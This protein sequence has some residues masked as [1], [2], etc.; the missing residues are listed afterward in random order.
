MT[1][2][3]SAVSWQKT[4]TY[5]SS[6]VDTNADGY[7]A[8]TQLLV[9]ADDA[10]PIILYDKDGV[11]Q[12][13]DFE[14]SIAAGDTVV[15]SSGHIMPDVRFSYDGDYIYIIQSVAAVVG[16]EYRI[17]KY[18]LDGTR[19][20]R[21]T[22]G[23]GRYGAASLC[24]DHNEKIYSIYGGGAAERNPVQ[25]SPVDGSITR[26]YASYTTYAVSKN[27]C[28]SVP[29]NRAFFG[30]DEHPSDTIANATVI[31]LALDSDNVI[32]YANANAVTRQICTDHEYVYTT[33]I[34]GIYDTTSILKL[35]GTTLA[36]EDSVN[37]VGACRLWI[38][39]DDNLWVMTDDSN[40]DKILVLDVDDLSTLSTTATGENVCLGTGVG[41]SRRC[42]LATLGDPSADTT[43]PKSQTRN[44][45]FPSGYG[46]LEGE[47]C[48]VLADGAVHPNVTVS[49]GL[50]TL[51]DTYT[52][53]HIGLRYDSRV[54]PMKID[55]EVHKKHITHVYPQ[56]Y[57]S[58][59]GKYGETETTLFTI[60]FRDAGDELNDSPDLY[61]GHKEL[62]FDGS[63]NR[64]GD[65]WFK[66]EQPLPMNLIGTGVRMAVENSTG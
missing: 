30:L 14:F 7:V 66:Q 41:K 46:H 47:E 10:S 11:D 39:Y 25:L 26:T 53:T 60:V 27:S 56:L 1:N 12:G 43:L 19:L 50:A 52:T 38:G 8:A 45:W 16:E 32:G 44:L 24:V 63:W 21:Q 17:H 61:T 5:D 55:G 22:F 9:T 65:V 64:T 51:N 3:T 54:Q 36:L 49:S 33:G 28:T 6:S 13:I 18:Q 37:V 29:L 42:A 2:S 59:G 58:L 20:W 62:P 4:T 57:E 35:N 48:Q 40:D 34:N 15:A 23:E 31:G